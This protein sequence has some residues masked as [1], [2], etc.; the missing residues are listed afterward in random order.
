VFPD[1]KMTDPRKEVGP[2][3]LRPLTQ[4]F[5]GFK[6][7]DLEAGEKSSMYVSSMIFKMESWPSFPVVAT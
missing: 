4:Q 3:F 7:P 1:F 5:A 2:L 6:D